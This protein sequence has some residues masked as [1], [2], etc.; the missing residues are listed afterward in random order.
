MKAFVFQGSG[1]NALENRS[2]PE[3]RL[4]HLTPSPISF[5]HDVE[6]DVRVQSGCARVGSRT[7]T[8]TLIRT[9]AYGSVRVGQTGG[10]S[11]GG[12]ARFPKLFSRVLVGLY[13]LHYERESP[14]P[15]GK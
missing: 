4:R 14:P 9:A 15:V 1:K 2:E 7:V 8:S 3:Q 11:R 13:Q 12:G 5:V 6:L 10:V